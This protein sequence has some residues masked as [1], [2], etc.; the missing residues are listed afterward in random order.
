MSARAAWRLESLGFARVFRYAGGKLDWLGFGLP[1][2][3][4]LAGFPTAL[5]AL[6]RDVPTCR[7]SERVGDAA[8]RAARGDWDSCVVVNDRRIVLGILRKKALEGDRHRTAEAA[9]EPGPVTVRPNELLAELAMR[10]RQVGVRRILV[11]TSDGELLGIVE[12]EEAER[13]TGVAAHL[14]PSARSPAA[15]APRRRPALRPSP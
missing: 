4:K 5:D 1:R 2:E 9:M 6:R 10:L 11:T 15:S 8:E 12:R 7:P 14:P 13:R 3:G